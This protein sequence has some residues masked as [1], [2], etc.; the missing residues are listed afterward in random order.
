MIIKLWKCLTHIK[1]QYV[2]FQCNLIPYKSCM[3]PWFWTQKPAWPFSKQAKCPHK[4]ITEMT[5]QQG[6][7][8]RR[9]MPSSVSFTS[10]IE[11]NEIPRIP[12]HL[13]PAFFYTKFELQKFRETEHKRA[14]RIMTRRTQEKILGYARTQSTGTLWQEIENHSL[15]NVY[16]HA[17]KRTT[18]SSHDH[19][20]KRP[21][22]VQ[23][24]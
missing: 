10:S 16:N 2:L 11:V 18:C 23:R 6:L 7:R 5:M 12:T 9:A 17:P 4:K 19:A 13:V 8:I 14:G 20:P 21:F 1:A 3:Q 24:A 15:H 22:S